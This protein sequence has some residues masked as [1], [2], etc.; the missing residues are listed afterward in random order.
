MPS[1]ANRL[2]PNSLIKLSEKS[3]IAVPICSCIFE[4][5]MRLPTASIKPR[6]KL[7]LLKTSGNELTKRCVSLKTVGITIATKPATKPET[8]IYD[9]AIGSLRP[10]PGIMLASLLTS[11]EIA[12]AKKSDAPKISS[13][14]LALKSKRPTI[15]SPMRTSQKRRKVFVSMLSL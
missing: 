10:S 12:S 15:T 2:L 3:L 5:P 9:R 14:A 6:S 4:M 13:P 11:G 7:A 1:V 8:M